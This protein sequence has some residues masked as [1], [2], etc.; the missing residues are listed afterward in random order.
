MLKLLDMVIVFY[1]YIQANHKIIR[2]CHNEEKW[3]DVENI[4][5][6][7]EIIK[8]LDYWK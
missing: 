2:F 3:Q 7:I 4:N 1:Y 8:N 6:N 5:C